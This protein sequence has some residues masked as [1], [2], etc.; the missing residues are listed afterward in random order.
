MMSSMAEMT[1]VVTGGA[2]GIGRATV[3]LLLSQGAS[4]LVADLRQSHVDAVVKELQEDRNSNGVAGCVMD[5]RNADDCERM[6]D[7]AEQSLGPVDAL[8]HCAGILRGPGSRPR[9]VHEID[10]A[11]YSAVMDTKRCSRRKVPLRRSLMLRRRRRRCVGRTPLSVAGV[12]AVRE[13]VQC[14]ATS[15]R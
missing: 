5:V 3:D 2:S 1:V 11:E 14:F 7:T 12:R 9:P 8:V 15:L 10:I 6:M 13:S 4:V